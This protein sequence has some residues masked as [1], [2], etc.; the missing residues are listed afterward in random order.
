MRILLVGRQDSRA[1]LRDAL[2]QTMTIVGEFE[3][4]AEARGAA[5]ESDAIVLPSMSAARRDT[6]EEFPVEALTPR[7]LQV[8][9]LLAEGLSNRD[10]GERL[11]ISSQTVK[12]HVTSIYGK[13]GA[14]NR[15]DAVRRAVRRGL[16]SL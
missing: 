1:R 7:E 6:L 3:T 15:P 14:A 11:G 16:V 9:Q 2:E 13:L 10:I 5:I 12:F 4:L 8:V